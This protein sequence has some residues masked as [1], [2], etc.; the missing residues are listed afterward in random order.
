MQAQVS[1]CLFCCN[2][3]VPFER[4]SAIDEPVLHARCKSCGGTTHAEPIARGPAL[5]VLTI[6]FADNQMLLI[7]RG[8]EP[9]RGFWAPPGGFVELGESLESAAIREVHEEVGI[10]LSADQLLPHTI[11]S[12]PSLNQ[13]YVIFLAVLDRAVELDPKL[14]EALDAGWFAE[15]HYPLEEV[16]PPARGFDMGRVFERVRTGRVDFYQLSGDWMRVLTN[17]E[18]KIDY[19][20]RR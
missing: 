9:Y 3:G 10:T 12:L 7:K 13:V 8:V 6:V 2:C 20:W 18:G 5:L 1:Q 4:G 17:S 16:W 11:A 15:H 19:L 14:P